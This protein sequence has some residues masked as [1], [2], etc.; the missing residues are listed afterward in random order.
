MI[1][2]RDEVIFYVASLVRNNAGCCF[3]RKGEFV[4]E[5]SINDD[6]DLL[7]N[8]SVNVTLWNYLKEAGFKKKVD[9]KFFNVYLYGSKPHVHYIN[10]DL[11]LHFDCVFGLFHKSVHLLREPG[12][13][14][15]HWVPLDKRIQEESTKDIRSFDVNGCTI[16]CLKLEVEL[17][18]LITHVILDK[19][20]RIDS[21]YKAR[22][23]YLLSQSDMEQVKMMLNLVFF[24][25][26]EYLIGCIRDEKFNSL[27]EE[28]LTYDGY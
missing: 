1:A 17:V 9:S 26:T 13:E 14:V 20:G 19:K 24:N 10:L 18:H 15:T 7:I 11:N 4:F 23:G 21:Y 3:L 28:Y 16:H 12:F 27:F 8:E 25:F 2:S 6:V 22:I 5:S